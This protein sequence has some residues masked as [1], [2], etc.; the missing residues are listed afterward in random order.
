VPAQ[1]TVKLLVLDPSLAPPTLEQWFEAWHA[2]PMTCFLPERQWVLCLLFTHACPPPPQDQNRVWPLSRAVLYHDTEALGVLLDTDVAAVITAQSV[3]DGQPDMNLLHAVATAGWGQEKVRTQMVEWVLGKAV[4]LG[5][6]SVFTTK[7]RF[8]KVPHTLVKNSKLSEAIRTAEARARK[9]AAAAKEAAKQAAAAQAA[10]K[11]QQQQAGGSGGEEDWEQQAGANG[12]G[13]GGSDAAGSGQGGKR[14]QRPEPQETPVE[15][16]KRR[17]GSMLGMLPEAL[18]RVAAGTAG[19]LAPSATAGD[20]AVDAAAAEADSRRAAARQRRKQQAALQQRLADIAPEQLP[21]KDASLSEGRQ[22]AEAP[23][24][25]PAAA[26]DEEVDPEEDEEEAE[27]EAEAAAAAGEGAV[28]G[29]ME[30]DVDSTD[31]GDTILEGLHWEFTITRDAMA[32]WAALD[33]WDAKAHTVGMLLYVVWEHPCRIAEYCSILLG[34]CMHQHLLCLSRVHNAYAWPGYDSPRTPCFVR[35]NISI[36]PD[37]CSDVTAFCLCLLAGCSKYRRLVALKLR[38]IGEGC[39]RTDG[40]TKKLR[41]QEPGLELWRTKFT[42]A[43]RLVW[44]VGA[45][46]LQATGFLELCTGVRVTGYS[47]AHVCTQQ[48]CSAPLS[49]HQYMLTSAVA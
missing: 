9:K 10:S 32:S 40:D 39:W 12:H 30:D 19:P 21:Q 16:C 14:K 35:P 5:C 27:R 34:A 1:K 4:Q 7:D 6:V 49:S 38:R 18:Q 47:S 11:K 43:G 17:V 46:R 37:M 28:A 13:D 44:Q 26:A 42:R 24:A 36:D 45:S 8:G 41:T 20:N 33:R 23:A 15:A 31:V 3:D 48:T 29:L 22:A 2:V 25:A